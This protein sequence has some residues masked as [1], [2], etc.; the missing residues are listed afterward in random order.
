MKRS[1]KNKNNKS[2]NFMTSAARIISTRMEPAELGVLMKLAR[3]VANAARLTAIAPLALLFSSASDAGAAEGPG[4]VGG[5]DGPR[6]SCRGER[7]GAS[8]SGGREA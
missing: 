6:D 1:D 8:W 5:A 4:A 7:S 3:D 2:R